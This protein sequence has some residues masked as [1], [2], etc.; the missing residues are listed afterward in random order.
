MQTSLE[1][2]A[3]GMNNF[4]PNHI[5]HIQALT[6]IGLHEGEKNFAFTQDVHLISP[7]GNESHP[8]KR[9]EVPVV[10]MKICGFPVLIILRNVKIFGLSPGGRAKIMD[11]DLISSNIIISESQYVSK[12]PVANLVPASF[13]KKVHI[14]KVVGTFLICRLDPQRR[15][16]LSNN[17]II[18]I[19]LESHDILHFLLFTG[20]QCQCH[21]WIPNTFTPTPV[22]K[23]LME[24]GLVLLG[25]DNRIVEIYMK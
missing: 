6:A 20:P 25:K 7:L 9:V 11:F 17:L 8:E 21:L 15:L 23:A 5:K 13:N 16:E 4:L 18:P 1:R 10:L 14:R 2:K 3:R 12:S 19:K 24:N 22:D